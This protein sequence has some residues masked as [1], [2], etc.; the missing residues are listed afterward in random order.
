[1]R[2]VIFL[3]TLSVGAKADIVE[4]KHK[5]RKEICLMGNLDPICIFLQSSPQGVRQEVKRIIKGV[6]LQGGHILNSGARISYET[7][8]E[9]VLAYVESAEE[10]WDAECNANP[11]E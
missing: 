2:E 6:S 8:L 11:S 9:N 4:V 5:L 7:P 3:R 1:M 10:Y